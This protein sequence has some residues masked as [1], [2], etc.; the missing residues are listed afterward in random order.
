MA[1]KFITDWFYG[2]LG[3][4]SLQ[5]ANLD[6]YAQRLQTVYESFDKA[7]YDVVQVVPI[8]ASSSTAQQRRDGTYVGESIF[9]ITRGA[10]V[11]GQKRSA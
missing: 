7:D 6:D 8:V 10:V 1:G 5:F 4:G 3:A 9:S 11:V 2:E